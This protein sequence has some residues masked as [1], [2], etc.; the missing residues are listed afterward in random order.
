MGTIMGTIPLGIGMTPEQE[1]EELEE[2]RTWETR[3]AE[4][5]QGRVVISGLK[6]PS[7][8]HAIVIE[9]YMSINLQRV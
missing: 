5:K 8:G 3:V 2:R 6:L 1:K 9:G 4:L 7:A